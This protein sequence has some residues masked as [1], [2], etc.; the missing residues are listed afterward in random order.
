[1]YVCVC[2]LRKDDQEL[3]QDVKGAID[4]NNCDACKESVCSRK[5][6]KSLGKKGKRMDDL[7]LRSNETQEKCIMEI[8]Y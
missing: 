1:M 2:V 5:L 6:R 7:D 3:I 4:A 8:P